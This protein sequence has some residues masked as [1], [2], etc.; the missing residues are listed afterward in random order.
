MLVVVMGTIGEVP[1]HNE[2][3]KQNEP[4]RAPHMDRITLLDLPCHH[5][6]AAAVEVVA[7]RSSSRQ[8]VEIV[9]SH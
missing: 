2:S 7:V 6:V 8:H 5:V 4:A 9:F 1:L 3:P